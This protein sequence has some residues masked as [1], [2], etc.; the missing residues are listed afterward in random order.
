MI[1]Q[2]RLENLEQIIAQIE[3]YEKSEPK[4]NWLD[5]LEGALFSC[6]LFGLG[7]IIAIYQDYSK[8]PTFFII[9]IGAI[10]LSSIIG[11]I[12]CLFFL[13]LGHQQNKDQYQTEAEK[14]KDII[15][16]VKGSLIINKSDESKD[17]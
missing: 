6:A 3:K 2:G 4:W 9:V 14:I 1:S 8:F 17:V 15:E 5:K 16:K 12:L 7:L 10:T 11:F 13:K